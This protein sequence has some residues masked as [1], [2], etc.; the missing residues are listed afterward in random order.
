ME[1]DIAE[2]VSVGERFDDVILVGFSKLG[3]VGDAK[4]RVADVGVEAAF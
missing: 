4:N 2:N 1:V 3:I